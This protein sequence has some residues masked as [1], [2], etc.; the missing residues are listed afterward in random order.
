MRNEC[1][2]CSSLPIEVSG[3]EAGCF[4]DRT[5]GCPCSRCL[6]K[7]MCE[8]SCEDLKFHAQKVKKH[9]GR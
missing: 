9:I 8:T 2:G 3:I 1:N 7:M 5:D 6:I 4:Y